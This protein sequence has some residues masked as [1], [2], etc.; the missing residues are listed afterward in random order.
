[1]YIILSVLVFSLRSQMF[2]IT[3]LLSDSLPA[4]HTVLGT[5]K[6]RC[7]E[8]NQMST[9]ASFVASPFGQSMKELYLTILGIFPLGYPH[10]KTNMA[11]EHHNF[12]YEN[13]GDILQG[14]NISPKN[15]ILKMIFLFPRWDMLIPWR[16]HFEFMVFSIV[17]FFSRV[18]SSPSLSWLV[19][20]LPPEISVS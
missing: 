2:C 20:L 19:N 1:M 4:N 12:Y 17:K 9:S 5:S 15:C 8:D 7:N 10:L 14:T 3:T 11:M 16:V 6:R 18:Y 13:I